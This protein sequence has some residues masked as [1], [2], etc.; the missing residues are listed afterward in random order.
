ML[1]NLPVGH[2]LLAWPSLSFFSSPRGFPVWTYAQTLALRRSSSGV[3][4]ITSGTRHLR[5]PVGNTRSSDV[6][7]P[8]KNCE[9]SLKRIMQNFVGTE[10]YL[11]YLSGLRSTVPSAPN[12]H[13]FFLMC[14]NV[15][16]IES[17]QSLIYGPY[18]SIYFS[19]HSPMLKKI[20][21]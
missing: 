6:M 12:E 16:V 10:W 7:L 14:Q 3:C 5:A 11:N 13:L 19:I 15:P 4:P 8:G 2:A 21:S 9:Y 20:S 18:S 17:S 1:T